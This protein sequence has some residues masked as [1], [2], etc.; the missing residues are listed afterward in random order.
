MPTFRKDNHYLSL[1]VVL[2]WCMTSLVLSLL[3]TASAAQDDPEAKLEALR[4]EIRKVQ[5]E[6]QRKSEAHSD[7]EQALERIEQQLAK[8]YRRAANLAQETD[9]LDDEL[10]TLQARRDDLRI[11]LEQHRELLVRQAR[12]AYLMGRQERLK[13]ILNQQDPAL[14]HRMLKYHDY[15][16]DAR[17]QRMQGLTDQIATLASVDAKIRERRGDLA[18][19][20]EAADQEQITLKTQARERRDVLKRLLAAMASDRERL[21]KMSRNEEQ[22]LELIDRLRRHLDDIPDDLAG[23]FASNRGKLPWPVDG[24]VLNRFGESRNVGKL[25][26]NGTVLGAAAGAKVRSIHPGRVIFADWLRGFGL[27]IIIDHGADYMTLYGYN[28]TL[29]KQVGDWVSAG[30]TVALVGDS[31]GQSRTGLYFEIRK[32]GKPIDPANWCRQASRDL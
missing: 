14:I 11:G 6:L 10:S 19:A 30:E 9:R 25:R 4:A 22:L 12:L 26:W 16:S 2:A 32:A 31:G 13:L 1:R 8:T 29:Y 24:E 20:R 23:D 17:H 15:L 27:L 21:G 5:R 18:Q 7:A 28:A 3:S